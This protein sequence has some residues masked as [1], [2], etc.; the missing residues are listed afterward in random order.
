MCISKKCVSYSPCPAERI[1][2]LA[3]P[4]RNSP[5]MA[6]LP[7]TTKMDGEVVKQHKSLKAY[8]ND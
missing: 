4:W 3:S 7:T 1:P 8:N 2:M 6:G 5:N